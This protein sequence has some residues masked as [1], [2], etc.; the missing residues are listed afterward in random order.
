MPSAE[1]LSISRALSVTDPS[2][3]P[4]SDELVRYVARV[5]HASSAV[6]ALIGRRRIWLKSRVGVTVSEVPHFKLPPDV[7]VVDEA[8]SDGERSQHPL[9]T[10]V[11]GA[12]FLAI[13]PLRD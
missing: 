11:P 8:S 4:E 12:T 1:L 5:C 2:P 13:A 10:L 6:L 9:L 7:E 3:D